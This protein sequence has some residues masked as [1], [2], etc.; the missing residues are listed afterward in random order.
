MSRENLD[1]VLE[2]C[3]RELNIDLSLGEAG[4]TAFEVDGTIEIEMTFDEEEPA[5]LVCATCGKMPQ[6]AEAR[7]ELLLD[8]LEANFHWIGTGGGTMSVNREENLVYLA[9][10]EPTEKLDEDRMQTILRTIVDNAEQW[11]RRLTTGD[12]KAEPSESRNDDD[13]S[14]E[15]AQPLGE[16][17][18][19]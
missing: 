2:K 18:R 10:K 11:H 16:M 3:G 1:A 12:W 4:Y 7:N 9:F 5:V 8:L 14:P 15:S 6:E 17:I 13:A 19:I